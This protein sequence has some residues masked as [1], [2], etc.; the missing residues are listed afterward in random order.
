VY[1]SGKSAAAGLT[2]FVS[3]DGNGRVCGWS[4]RPLAV[5]SSSLPIMVSTSLRK[6]AGAHEAFAVHHVLS[7]ANAMFRSISIGRPIPQIRG[8]GGAKQ[9]VRGPLQPADQAEIKQHQRALIGQLMGTA[10]L[11]DLRDH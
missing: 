10:M 11:P 6:R 8:R 5:C 7:S 9:R 4:D 1:L 3:G 2:L